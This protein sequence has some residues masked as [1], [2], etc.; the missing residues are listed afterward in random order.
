MLESVVFDRMDIDYKFLYI[1][2]SI[3]NAEYREDGLTAQGKNL[4]LNSPKGAALAYKEK[5]NN[6][7]FS[8]A[9]RKIFAK[10]YW[11]YESINNKS[12]VSKLKNIRSLNLKFH[13]I[14]YFIRRILDKK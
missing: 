12:F 10:N 4:F 3:V 9:Y 2:T 6:N 13:M 5:M 11:D 7:Q 14:V 8:S 1:N